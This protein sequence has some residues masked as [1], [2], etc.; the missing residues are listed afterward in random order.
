MRKMPTL[1][2]VLLFVSAPAIQIRL[3]YGNG[4]A[5]ENW[6]F[7]HDGNKQIPSLTQMLH[8]K[9]GRK[10]NSRIEKKRTIVKQTLRRQST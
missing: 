8:A 1:S 4:N 10:R 3:L 9:L 7:D 6:S 5:N 2:T